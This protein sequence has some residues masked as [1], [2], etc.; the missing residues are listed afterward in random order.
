MAL[1]S[2]IEIKVLDLPGFYHDIQA[3]NKL[4]LFELY[5]KILKTKNN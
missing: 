3:N 1:A 4:K 2:D 5:E